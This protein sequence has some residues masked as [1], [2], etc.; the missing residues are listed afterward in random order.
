[1][2]FKQFPIIIYDNEGKN[3]NFT[4]CVNIMKRIALRAEAKTNILLFDRY[5]VNEGET[6]EMI[7]Y[8]VYGDSTLHWTILLANEITDRFHEWPMGLN[9]LNQF[10]A[11]KYSN[12][13]GVHHYEI[14]YTSGDTTKTINIGTDKTNHAAATTVT[15]YEY[16]LD[17]QDDLRKIRLIDSK[18]M[19]QFL[20][21]F[22]T[23]IQESI[24]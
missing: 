20:D 24:I 1:M 5:E 16:E 14:L 11:D 23:L 6:P 9:E 12:I 22:S 18:H 4:F 7:A 19:P 15:N 21:E 8:K 17:R 2:Y 13:N 3:R 10:V